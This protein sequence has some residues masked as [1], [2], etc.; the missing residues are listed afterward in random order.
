M[1]YSNK[2]DCLT[3]LANLILS[4]PITSLNLYVLHSKLV[5]IHSGFVKTDKWLYNTIIT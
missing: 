1:Y 5:S 2:S 4:K 3:E